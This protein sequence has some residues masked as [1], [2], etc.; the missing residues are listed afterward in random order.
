MGELQTLLALVVLIYVLCV[1]VQAA[2]EIIKSALNT[3]AK[4]MA[5]T[6]D[7]FMGAHL[8]LR[9][10]K[11]AL[12]QRGLD[13]TALER[14]NKDDFRKLLDGIPFTDT[15]I[16][17]IPAVVATAGASV[18]QLKEQMAASYDA[19]L[20]TFQQLYAKNNK[21]WVVGISFAVVLGL[22][23]SLIR[24]YDTL[25]VDQKM[26]QAIAG[27]AVTVANG[28]AS[29]Q[30]AGAAQ[31]DD[32]EA[33][34]RKNRAAIQS[35]LKNYPVL[36]RTSQ[37]PKDIEEPLPEIFGL[38]MMGLLVS[39]GAPFWNDVLKGA[40][41]INNVLNTGGKTNRQ[42]APLIPKAII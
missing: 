27:T 39:L 7:K 3:K 16:R 24:I 6:I 34:Y 42:E 1:I 29:N 12:E 31:N 25:S 40:N 30:N 26:S 23:A 4:T 17:Q 36:L 18:D 15:Q 10:V 13:I 5:A 14:F 41:G 22:N 33:V 20:A 2:Q 19:A 11:D 38:L 32:L 21:K 35:D 9:Q 37:Y 8:D 28:G